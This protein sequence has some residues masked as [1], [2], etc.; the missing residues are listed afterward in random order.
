MDE[1]ENLERF[2]FEQMKAIDVRTVERD[3]LIDII[4]IQIDKNL[5][6]NER[7]ADFLKQVKNP[8]CYR[9][10]KAV[11]KVSFSDTEITLEKCLERYLES[12]LDR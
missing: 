1:I 2:D 10:G 12:L 4:D 5:P 7:F 6:R 9:C 11:V 8:Y 3:S